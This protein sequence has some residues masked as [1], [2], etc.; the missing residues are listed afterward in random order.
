MQIPNT[1]PPFERWCFAPS[2]GTCSAGALRAITTCVA[3]RAIQAATIP[4][5]LQPSKVRA[6]V[7]RS[8]RPRVGASAGR[9]VRG[10]VGAS[11]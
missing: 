3:V 1:F 4:H 10:R 8:A 6:S 9:R 7:C 11:A 5:P 2:E